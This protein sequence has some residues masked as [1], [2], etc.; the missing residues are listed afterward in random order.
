MAWYGTACNIYGICMVFEWSGMVH[1]V[2]DELEMTVQHLNFEM[3]TFKVTC[4]HAWWNSSWLLTQD[5]YLPLGSTSLQV[6]LD[7]IQLLLLSVLLA[8]N[9]EPP[10]PASEPDQVLHQVIGTQDQLDPQNV[11]DVRF[12]VATPR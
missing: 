11:L 3:L 10:H 2:K 8:A 6:F 1:F 4:V 7:E 9:P 12:T 5:T